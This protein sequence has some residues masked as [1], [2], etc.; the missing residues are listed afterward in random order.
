MNRLI[1][2][3]SHKNTQQKKGSKPMKQLIKLKTTTLL[4][5]PLVLACFALLPRA[6]GGET[7][8]PESATVEPFPAVAGFNTRDGFN[9][10]VSLTTGTFNSAF[11][12]G[13]LRFDTTGGSNTALGAQALLSNTTGGYNTAI[14][15]NALIF[16]TSGSQNMALGQGALA[17][18]LHG[19]ANTA[20]GF[21]AL[22]ANT[23]TGNV[24]VGFQ[25]LFSNT[26]GGTFVPAD[27]LGPNTAIGNVAAASNLTGSNIN[28]IGFAAL[29]SNDGVPPQGS[30]NNAHGDFALSSN[31]TGRQNN[32]FGDQA[33]STNITGNFNTAIGDFAGSAITRNWNIDIGKDVVGIGGAMGDNFVTRIGISDEITPDPHRQVACFIGGIYGRTIGPTP[34]QVGIG[35]DGKLGTTPSSKRFKHDIKAMD[36]ASDA[37]LALKPVTFHYKGDSTNTPEFGLIAEDVEKVNPALVVRVRGKIYSVRYDAVNA[38]LLNEFL[39][40]HQTV[41][42]LKSIVAKQEATV[43]QQQNQ[44][45]ALTSGLQKVSA[46][47]EASKPAPQMVS[48]NQ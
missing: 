20:M 21:Q 13:A 29:L 14:G 9:A 2:L 11:G 24:A 8:T 6:Q 41:Q 32:A 17:G 44:I 38:M 26:T 18:N 39:K 35:A 42:E 40:E 36:K 37:I 47:L 30:F 43:A 10:L 5:I 22:N 25:A 31:T 28:A 45:E 7:A 23:T 34:L 46:Q 16:N 15:E 27:G 12:F 48:S 3:K 33:L 4:V 19:D 1:H